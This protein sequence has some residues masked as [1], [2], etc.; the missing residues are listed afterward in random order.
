[1]GILN[2]R[3]KGVSELVSDILPDDQNIVTKSPENN[4]RIFGRNIVTRY[5]HHLL[6]V[7]TMIFRMSNSD[8]VTSQSASRR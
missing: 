3:P 6:Q 1:M 4:L 2:A 7:G 8:G 5:N